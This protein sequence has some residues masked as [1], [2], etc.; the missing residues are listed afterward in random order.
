MTTETAQA[1]QPEQTTPAVASENNAAPTVDNSSETTTTSEQTSGDD[2]AAT[3]QPERKQRDGGF[4][5]R[6]NELTRAAHEKQRIIDHLLEQ[7][8][9]STGRPAAAD[10]PTSAEPKQEDFA[11]YDQW[12]TA[13][14]DHRL[15][16]KLEQ[17]ERERKA[18]EERS[19]AERTAAERQASLRKA[20]EEAASKYPDFEDALEANDVPITQAMAD[21][22]D[23]SDRKVDLLWWLAKNP[24]EAKR[25]AGLSP[26]SQARHLARIEYEKLAAAQ[27]QKTVS[28]AP[29]PP[30][31]VKGK[32]QPAPNPEKM[33]MEEYVRW[34]RSS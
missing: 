2:A 11:S 20:A 5:R 1:P 26:V 32:G 24:D 34:R 28:D 8:R 4:Q 9:A 15:N 31:T 27:P 13:L 25:I 14:I 29:E 10:A 23:E 30:R 18:A 19:K 7:Q 21:A 6:I 16:A 33:T 3:D 12:Q 22:I 17:R